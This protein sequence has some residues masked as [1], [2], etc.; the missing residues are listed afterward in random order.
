MGENMKFEMVMELVD[1][2]D[3]ASRGRGAGTPIDDAAAAAGG[4]EQCARQD[5]D[6]RTAPATA[7]PVPAS[8][9]PPATSG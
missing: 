8:L 2:A 5:Q 1:V 7:V 9:R 6:D 3:A 4:Q